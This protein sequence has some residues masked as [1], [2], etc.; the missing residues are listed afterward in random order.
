MEYDAGP[1]YIKHPLDLAGR[2][3]DIF[4]RAAPI[5]FDMIEKIAVSEPTPSPQDGEPTLFAR[6]T[7]EQ[8]EIP[9]GSSLSS[10]YDHIRMLDAEGYPRAYLDHGAVRIEF[11]DALLKSDAAGETVTATATILRRKSEGA[12]E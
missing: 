2:A 6:R 9:P 12:D 5:I 8:S 4:E 7:P 3:Q 10:L 11:S 1:V